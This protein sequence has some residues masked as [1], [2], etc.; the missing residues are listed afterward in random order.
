MIVR[1]TK[2]AR[3]LQRC[4]TSTCVC[5]GKD[6][7][8]HLFGSIQIETWALSADGSHMIAAVIRPH[9][10]SV[11]AKHKAA[12]GVYVR[13]LGLGQVMRVTVGLRA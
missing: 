1:T 6:G 13:P 9:R 7:R 11:C 4:S 8:G 12:S 3:G 5:C 2:Q 10:I